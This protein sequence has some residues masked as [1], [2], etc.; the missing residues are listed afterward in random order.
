MR[1]YA[2]ILCA[3]LLVA[4]TDDDSSAETSADGTGAPDET[5]SSTEG[6]TQGAVD[7]TAG[8]TA[9]T[10]S[11]VEL[12]DVYD[13]E[14]DEIF[15]EGV[16]WDPVT[17]SFY[18]GSVHDG[19]IR[20]IAADGTQAMFAPAPG[21]DWSSSGLKVDAAAR[22]LWVC[23]GD[24]MEGGVRGVHVLD[25]DTAEEITFFDLA[26]IDPD[27]GCNDLA[28][29]A[30]GRAYVSDPGL[31]VV[32][33]LALPDAGE[34]WAEHPDFA[35]ELPGLG[36]NGLAVTP[37]Q[38]YLVLAKFITT[39]LFRIALD[40]PGDVV[41]IELSGDEFSGE[42]AIS[43]A[44]GIIFVGDD[45]YVVFAESVKR[46]ELAD[47]WS[48]G[49]VTHVEVPGAGNGL[50]T[51]TAAD[52]SA[53]VVKSEITAWVIRADPELPFQIIRVP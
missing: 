5:A 17:Q 51:A 19:V 48:T 23:T 24:G 49:V 34:I 44:D 33:R 32:H 9:G 46:V 40:D 47:D 38:T 2:P 14:G 41:D 16:T 31:S 30:E 22:R 45:L 35:Q 52:G 6:A 11:G 15:P 43:G 21:E 53:F 50:S 37:D 4:C 8:D 42:A 10:G 3:G 7:E 25:L 27:G 36:L 39:R 12:M 29:D 1:V 18:V 28:L 13:L 26:D 20:S